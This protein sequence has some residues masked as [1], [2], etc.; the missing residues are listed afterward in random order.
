MGLRVVILGRGEMLLNLIRGSMLAGAEIVGVFR[1]ERLIFPPIFLKFYDFFKSSPALTFTKKHKIYDIPFTSANSENFKRFLVKE[2]VDVVLVGS[3]CEKLKKEIIDIPVIGTVNV[4]PSLLPQYR[5]PNPYLQTILHGE[6][7]S[8][9]TFHLM[10]EKYDAGPV[11]A[12][13]EIEILQGD[14]G[15]ELKNKTVFQARLLCANLLEKLEGGFVIPVEQDESLATYYENVKP[16][17]MTLVF[18][19]ET[20]VENFNPKIAFNPWLKTYF[21]Y[22]N[23]FFVINPYKVE[24]VEAAGDAGMIIDAGGLS[25]TV[26]AINGKALKMS[27][28]RLYRFPLF[29]KF[30]INAIGKTIKHKCK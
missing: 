28:L 27:D 2:N 12:Q 18:K 14:T 5:G 30:F 29:T 20:K 24:I 16:E 13:K 25:L 1:Y 26:A 17:D 21:Q 11:L 9:V 3:W 22:G 23:T 19:N 8:G 4:H 10:T 7:K 15:K 6:K